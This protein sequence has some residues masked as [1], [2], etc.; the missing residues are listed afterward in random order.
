MFL[1]TGHCT[2]LI[3]ADSARAPADERQDDCDICRPPVVLV[4]ISSFG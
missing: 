4:I 3:V 1:D 2:A